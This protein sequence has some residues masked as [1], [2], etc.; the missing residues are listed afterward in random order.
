MADYGGVGGGGSLRDALNEMYP[1]TNIGGYGA[2]FPPQAG[3]DQP[4]AAIPLPQPRPPMAPQIPGALPA[5]PPGTVG[6]GG[7]PQQGGMAANKP[8]PI[9][10]TK[11]PAGQ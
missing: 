7:L 10:D 4:G 5:M 8:S 3:A 11:R 2:M 9:S 1:L 6:Q